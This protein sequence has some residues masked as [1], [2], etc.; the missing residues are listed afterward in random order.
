MAVPY[1]LEYLSPPVL[2]SVKKLLLPLFLL[3]GGTGN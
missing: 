3:F 1:L 2:S